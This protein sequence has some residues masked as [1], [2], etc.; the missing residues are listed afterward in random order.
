MTQE[1][2]PHRAG[3]QRTFHVHVFAGAERT[4]NQYLIAVYRHYR[5]IHAETRDT[6]EQARSAAHEIEQEFGDDG[7]AIHI[8][9]E[10]GTRYNLYD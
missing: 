4:A 10:H 9:D 8:V 1:L 6:L 7:A 2:G 3:I 5:L